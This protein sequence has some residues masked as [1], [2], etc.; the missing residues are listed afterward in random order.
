MPF[1][2]YAAP[3]LRLPGAINIVVEGDPTANLAL[4]RIDGVYA[5]QPVRNFDGIPASGQELVTDCEAPLGRSVSYHLTDGWGNILAASD[6]VRAPRLKSRRALLRSPLTPYVSWLEVDPQDE[7]NV[8][9]E[10]STA[11]HRVLG[12]DTPVVIGEV[13]Q[14]HSGTMNFLARSITEADN[15][16]RLARDGNML[17]LRHDPC[18]QPQTRDMMLFP[19]DVTEVRYGRDGWRILSMDY[20]STQFVAGTTMEPDFDGTSRRCPIPPPTSGRR[21]A[22]GPTSA[23]RPSSRCRRGF[24]VRGPPRR[25]GWSMRYETVHGP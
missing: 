15:I 18:A 21:P 23:C 6:P 16:V 5:A 9:W 4:S 14:R 22:C 1:A 8:T 20:Q 3:H 17:L 2:I 12:S 24:R 11:V 10:T 13:R 7:K 19:L 25:R